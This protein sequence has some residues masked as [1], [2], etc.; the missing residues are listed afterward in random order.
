MDTNGF[1]PPPRVFQTHALLIELRVQ[2]Q[3]VKGQTNSEELLPLQG[4][5]YDAN[6]RSRDVD[7]DDLPC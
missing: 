7:R 5:N 2:R 1:A 4:S 3:I 6:V